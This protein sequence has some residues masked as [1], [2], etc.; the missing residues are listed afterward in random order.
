MDENAFNA[1]NFPSFGSRSKI[2]ETL[3]VILVKTAFDSARVFCALMIRA[4][5]ITNRNV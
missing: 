1:I 4:H 5:V 2:S 3:K